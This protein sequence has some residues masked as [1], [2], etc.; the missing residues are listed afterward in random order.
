MCIAASASHPTSVRASSFSFQI[1]RAM[2]TE[3][4]SAPSSANSLRKQGL[5]YHSS[6][7]TPFFSALRIATRS[8]LPTAVRGISR[9][10]MSFCGII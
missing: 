1:C 5:N 10:K 3:R 7:S 9:T 4:C 8:I 6:R 2:P